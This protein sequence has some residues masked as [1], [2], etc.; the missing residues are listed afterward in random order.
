MEHFKEFNELMY[1]ASCYMIVPLNYTTGTVDRYHS[2]WRRIRSFMGLYC[3]RTYSRTVKELF[4]AEELNG[5]A[6]E[7]FSHDHQ[8]TLRSLK[9]L[10]EF[11]EKGYITVSPKIVKPKSTVS[12]DGPI[13]NILLSFIEHRN[14]LYESQF[15]RS[16]HS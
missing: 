5:R 14:L 2:H 6:W 13:G 11:T 10:T 3:I 8:L 9:A 1:R 7:E 4:I 12:L 16:I 15:L